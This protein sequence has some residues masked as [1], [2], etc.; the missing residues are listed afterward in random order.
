[1]RNRLALKSQTEYD[2][3]ITEYRKEYNDNQTQFKYL[4]NSLVVES[5]TTKET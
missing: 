1:V 5:L 4:E 3:I 2:Y